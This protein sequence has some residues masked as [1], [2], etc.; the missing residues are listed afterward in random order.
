M[1]DASDNIPGVTGIGEKTA[2]KIITEYG[3]LENAIANAAN[4]RPPRAA[5]NLAAEAETARLS[6]RLAK[7]DDNAPVDI[8][9]SDLVI[10]NIYTEDARKEFERLELRFLLKRFAVTPEEPSQTAAEAYFAKHGTALDE[11]VFNTQIAAYLLED[12]TI[13]DVDEM[14]G[15]IAEKGLEYLFYQVEMPLAGILAEMEEIG[16]KVCPES[17]RTF[18]RELDVIIAEK[19]AKIHELAGEAFNINS[20]KQLGVILF[21][22]LMLKG[23]KKTKSKTLSTSAEVLESLS[24]EHEII[25]EILE[26]R[27]VSKLKSTYVD[28]L[29]AQIGDDGRIHTKFH[30]T[31]TATGRLSS[32]NPN[33]QNIPIRTE[34]GR[35][36]R[37]AFIPEDGYVFVDADY[38]QIELRLLAHLSRDETFIKA[39]NDGEDIHALT[40]SQVFGTPLNEVSQEQ[41]RA[42]KAVNFGIIY[43]MSAFRLG[44]DLGV[45]TKNAE[46]YIN[47]YFA[48]Y[49]AVKGYLDGAVEDARK[50]GFA[51]TLY[52]RTRKI[53]ELYADNFNTRSFGERV[54]MNMPIQ[55]AAADIIKIA[56][57]RVWNELKRR[58]LKSRLI[59]Q[60]H[61]ELLI[62]AHESEIDEVC[63]LVKYEMEN[64]AELL[65]K[66]SVD[67]SVKKNW[68][69]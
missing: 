52:G 48:R 12:E 7:I 14:K 41:R 15:L 34:L 61:D 27:T 46:E 4:I 66:L 18:G 31:L 10:K 35:R 32:S 28:G 67:V 29:S 47:G 38:S 1:G 13:S 57:I 53:P 49:P 63:E 3:D 42:A 6:Y 54:A 36:L 21:E 25:D 17:L 51:A 16:V 60:V 26:Y 44:K 20:P 58:G 50:T 24:G 30:Q 62:E 40:A 5:A 68:L 37:A 65:V 33:L 56:M 43:G 2:L 22:K 64:A 59:L 55:G 23:G 69:D 9:I 19:Q 11:T 8:S 39:F 45:G